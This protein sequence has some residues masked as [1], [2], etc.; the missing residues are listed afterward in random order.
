M[1]QR[2]DFLNGDFKLV[3]LP[4]SRHPIA[5]AYRQQLQANLEGIGY[6]LPAMDSALFEA[7][8]VYY[9][10]IG[11]LLEP[12][13]DVDLLTPESRHNFFICTEPVPSPADPTQFVV[14][15]SQLDSLLGMSYAA[16]TAKGVSQVV[17]TS[18]DPACDLLA[19]LLLLFKDQALPLADRL[20]F[21]ALNKLVTQAAQR[22][23]P[24]LQKKLQNDADKKRFE[25]LNA[26]A[27]V[28]EYYKRQGI[29]VP[30]DF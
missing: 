6:W 7:W 4:L 5:T 17:I 1:F 15:L 20:S 18:G 11:E 16:P 24:E 12:A 14:G 13:V 3:S 30:E 2:V 10:R 29:S 21:S 22:K 19:D 8:G 23:D 25:Q 28:R 27:A 26:G 9:K